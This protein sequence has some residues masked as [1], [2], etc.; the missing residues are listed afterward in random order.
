MS[1]QLLPKQRYSNPRE[2]GTASCSHAAELSCARETHCGRPK[3]VEFL[4]VPDRADDRVGWLSAA[5]IR[6]DRLIDCIVEADARAA[7]RVDRGRHSCVARPSCQLSRR[8]V[9]RRDDTSGTNARIAAS[10]L[11]GENVS[12]IVTRVRIIGWVR[13]RR[14]CLAT[15]RHRKRCGRCFR[16]ARHERRR[17]HC[18][19]HANALHGLRPVRT[20]RFTSRQ[21]P[22]RID[23][24]TVS[25]SSIGDPVESGRVHERPTM[26]FASLVD[27]HPES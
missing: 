4:D 12:P 14:C 21:A 3:L 7:S 17:A 10:P 1:P 19:A 18:E 13:G 26:I 15:R 23:V 8:S 27:F 25:D 9:R 2:S 24:T 6:D 16:G 20:C 11:F 5:R 22:A